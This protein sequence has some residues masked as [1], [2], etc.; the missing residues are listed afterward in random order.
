MPNNIGEPRLPL[1]SSTGIVCDQCANDKFVEQFFIRKFSKFV[2][3]TPNDIL[4]TIPALVC[5]NCGHIN[6]DLN[7]FKNINP[8]E[9][10]V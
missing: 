7:P 4:Q 2:T 9:K 1:A 3:M 10:P 8:S 5:S 6:D